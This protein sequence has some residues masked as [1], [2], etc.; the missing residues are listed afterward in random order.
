MLPGLLSTGP[1]L[2][3]GAA[4]DSG[5]G[6]AEVDVTHGQQSEQYAA[7]TQRRNRQAAR[8]DVRR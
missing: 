3:P 7:A 4:D 1:D 6:E 2:R 8:A 5:S